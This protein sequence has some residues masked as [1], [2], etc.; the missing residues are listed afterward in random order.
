[1]INLRTYQESAVNELAKHF[2]KITEAQ[3][4]EHMLKRR[5]RIVF[6]APT[7]AGKTVIMASF[8][9][10]ITRDL[11]LHLNLPKRQFAFIW[12]APNQLHEQSQQAL[13]S[14]FEETRTLRCKYFSDLSDKAIK[15]GDILFLN[16]E[17]IWSTKNNI[18]KDGEAGPGLYEIIDATKSKGIE[19]VVVIDEAHR[20]LNGPQCQN[21]LLQ[22]DSAIEI[23]VTATPQYKADF[24]VQIPRIAVIKEGMIKKSI[25]LNPKISAEE[26]VTLNELLI[27]EAIKKRESIERLYAKQ[28]SSVRPLLLIQLPNDKKESE[29]SLDKTIH[30]QVVKSLEAKGITANNGKLAI[31]LSK[32]KIHKS[33][34]EIKPFNSIVEVMLFKQAI[35]LGWDCPRAAVL[36]IFRELGDNS[37]ATQTV[38]RILRMP[39]HHHYAD[40]TLNHGYV[41]TD[42]SRDVIDI[43]TDAKDYITMDTA[44]RVGNYEELELQKEHLRMWGSRN[45]LGAR[46][47]RALKQAAQIDGWKDPVEYPDAVAYNLRHLENKL[48]HI[49]PAGISIQIPRDTI[50][51]QLVFDGGLI[52]V[53]NRT[54]IAKTMSELQQLFDKYC[55]ESCAPF[56]V[57][58][59]AGKLK[60]AIVELIGDY[61]KTSEQDAYKLVLYSENQFYWNKLIEEAKQIFQAWV[62]QA[63]L[64]QRLVEVVP[65]EVPED[66]CYFGDQYKPS[67]A[68]KHVLQEYFEPRDGWQTEKDFVVFLERFGSCLRWWYKNGDSGMEHFCV[69]YTS[70]ANVSSLFYPDFIV[71]FDN[72]TMGFFD[73][74]TKDS[75]PEAAN[76]HNALRAYL[77]KL[78][79]QT[80]K[81]Y[82]GGVIIQDP[83][84]SQVWK[85]SATDIAN[86]YDLTGWNVLDFTKQTRRDHEKD[87]SS[88]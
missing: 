5:E 68:P 10:L 84:E 7:G 4:I 11:P 39:E 26:G 34:E 20:N 43:K 28:G 44:K 60:M 54:G 76:K 3:Q 79:K 51:D 45:V 24:T 1:M 69:S 50:L 87:P 9:Q 2:Y 81:T 23:E 57:H 82:I 31:W 53:K 56:E 61:L 72:G 6:Q 21:V 32:E 78:S 14:F 83:P 85:M 80:G 41:Y 77:H 29:S 30:Q 15:E 62:D 67:I 66:R 88:R 18:I 70:T 48:V 13:R 37:F 36:L 12:L 59:S 33:D 74:K 27:K 35:A 22:I 47:R 8:L 16:W 63:L 75:D 71:L 49:H 58:R 52:Q 64:R 40:D 73:T 86:T 46:I 55:A 17:S 65:W 42:L 19:I 38:G 25:V